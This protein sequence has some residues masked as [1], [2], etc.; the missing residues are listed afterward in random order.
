MGSS[1]NNVPSLD[2]AYLV[3]ALVEEAGGTLTVS[4]EWFVSDQSPFEGKS[5]KMTET[6]GLIQITLTE[7]ENE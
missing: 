7:G 6:D 3:A 1:S 2:I 5:L 4:T